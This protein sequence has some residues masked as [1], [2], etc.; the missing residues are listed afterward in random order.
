MHEHGSLPRARREGLLEETVGEELLL[1]DQDSHTAHCLSPIAA[2]VWRHC[3]G[4]HDLTDLATLAGTSESLVVDA[5]H[6][7]R[8]KD[9]LDAEPQLT[10]SAIPGISRREAIVRVGRVGAGAAAATMIVSATA[11]TPAMAASGEQ[12]CC[13]C[14]EKNPLKECHCGNGTS[15]ECDEICTGLPTWT[16]SAKLTCK[17]IKCE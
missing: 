10:Q 2:Y 14:Y 8:D 1:Y 6:E 17:G 16:W 9:L 13:Q 11:A 4:E 3:D 5:V 15:A 12:G 7:L